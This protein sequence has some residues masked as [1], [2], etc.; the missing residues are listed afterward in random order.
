MHQY[1][2]HG[3]NKT[4][5]SSPQT[6]HYKNTVDDCSIK[7]GGR[8]CITNLDKYKIPKS[9][10]GVLPC[11]PLLP[12]TD[13]ECETLPHVVRASDKDWDPTSLDC[14]GQLDNEE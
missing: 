6:E 8:Q 14:K 11:I 9:I 4:I 12:C 5:N 1:A 13:K 2:Y 7:V 3:K 10:Q